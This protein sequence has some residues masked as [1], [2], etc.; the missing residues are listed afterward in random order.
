[1]LSAW[2]FGALIAILTVDTLAMA[3]EI[4]PHVAEAQGKDGITSESESKSLP[5][6]NSIMKHVFGL[7]QIPRN[8]V[9][10][11]HIVYSLPNL[12]L[13]T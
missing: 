1:M 5:P 6:T 4:E 11:E 13:F 9:V 10:L 8:H 3:K 12:F 7:T 2:Q